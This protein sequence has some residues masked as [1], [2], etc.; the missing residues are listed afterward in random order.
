M[1]E[2]KKEEK[3]GGF[4]ASLSSLFG[5]GSS[6][7][8]TGM[9]GASGLGSMGSGLGGLFATKAGILGMVLGG[10]TIAAGVGVV[11]NFIGPSSK[12]VYS[13]Q[14]FQDT[15]YEEQANN[16]GAERAKQREE[17][18]ASASTLDMFRE[19][20]K[21]DGLGLGEGGA[22]AEDKNAAADAS[23]V[24]GAA[25]AAA[26]ADGA[27]AD[28]AANAPAGGSGAK[29]QGS[30][31][32]GSKG[33]GGGTASNIPRMSGGGGN[34]GGSNGQFASLKAPVGKGNG[35]SG[36]MKGSKAASIKGSSKYSV[37]VAKGKNALGQAKF[38]GGL[39]SKAAQGPSLAGSKTGATEAFSGE[40]AGSGDVGAPDGGAGL[41]GAGITSAN[42]LKGSDPSINSSEIT[43]PKVADPEDVSPW[44]KYTDMAMYGMLA[45]GVLIFIANMIAKHAATMM[46]AAMAMPCTDPI[47]AG[48]KAAA[49]V[50]AQ[51][52][53]GYASLV[54]KLAMAAAAVVI[55][56]GLKL[57][58]GDP[59]GNPPWTG[60]K[61]TGIMYMVAGGMLMYKAYEAMSGA[62]TASAAE[63]T[64]A[65]SDKA[66]SSV[67]AGLMEEAMEKLL[68]HQ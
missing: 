26:P 8:A 55:F 50:A 49:I 20:A 62:N 22:A 18:S 41:G 52:M 45:A 36:A 48:L 68:G 40:T 44:T 47:T 63:I 24:D 6:G 53:Y 34:F 51:T 12:P 3:K 57:M 23:A 13:P 27:S 31:G 16:A 67:Q 66:N 54:A 32:F 58:K 61:W 33:A 30:L 39:G 42:K 17:A 60:Q 1:S 43:P 35:K 14:L 15:Y 21:K 46:K 37:P 10:A 5:G 11:Y 2:F 28:S 9:G 38:A 56:A 29:L 4:W 64:N 7:A 25:G 59:D 19:Q 65:A